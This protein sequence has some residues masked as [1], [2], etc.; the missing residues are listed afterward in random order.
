MATESIEKQQQL[1]LKTAEAE[2]S[3]FE[4]LLKGPMGRVD[5]DVVKDWVAVLVKHVMPRTFDKTVSRTLQNCVDELDA[6]ISRQL[7]AIMHDKKFQKLEGTW[8]GL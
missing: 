5:E 6:A 2:V 4:Q 8:R 7:A 3:L 1:Q